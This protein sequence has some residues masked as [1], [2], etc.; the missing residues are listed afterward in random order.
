M[1]E[2]IVTL[3][4]RFDTTLPEAMGYAFLGA[5]NRK[6]VLLTDF[7]GTQMSIPFELCDDKSVRFAIKIIYLLFHCVVTH[8]YFIA[9]SQ[10]SESTHAKK[11]GLKIHRRTFLFIICQ[12]WL[13][14][15]PRKFG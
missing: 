4:H 13:M 7:L 6:P 15:P 12:Y 14:Q 2:R 11:A 9:V 10:F 3:C 8:I 5:P 1:E